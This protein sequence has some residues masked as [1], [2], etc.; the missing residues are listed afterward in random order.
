MRVALPSPI[1]PGDAVDLHVRFVTTLPPIFARTGYSEDFHVVA[2]WFPKIARRE[3]GGRWATFPYHGNGEFYADFAD[4]TLSVHAPSGWIVGANGK[5]RDE[6]REGLHRFEATQVHD[7]AFVAWPSFQESRFDAD[8]VRV[9]VLFPPGYENATARHIAMVRTGLA[10]MGARFGPYPWETLTVIV[11]PRGAEGASGMEY[12]GMF[13]TAGDA[14]TLEGLRY[15]FPEFVTAHELAHQWF[16]GA[17]ATDEV[18]WPMLDEGI[19]EWVSLDL[20]RVHTGKTRGSA[21]DLLGLSVDGFDIARSLAMSPQA[22]APGK[23]AYAFDPDSYGRS[24]YER[25]ATVLETVRRVW[26]RAKF[27]A[28]LS[29]YAR[30]HRFAHPTPD[31]LFRAFDQAYFEGFSD[32]V[33]RPALLDG[34]VASIRITRF[35]SEKDGASWRV[36]LRAERTGNIPVPTWVAL[37]DPKGQTIA[38]VAWAAREAE[39]RVT[40]SGT[41]EVASAEID[42]DHAI[43]LDDP[44]DN[45][46]AIESRPPDALFSR[47]LFLAQSLLGVFAP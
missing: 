3:P 42:P 44:L 16:Y 4:V 17:I 18:T 30:D 38:R 47:L 35:S 46:A 14:W 41:D 11:P 10:S 6:E 15:P 28:A 8:G 24:V 39:L 19:T 25:T 9:R 7:V 1:A 45:S 27:D 23:P 13:V 22:R 36:D 12:P 32:A 2:Q 34:E 26:G 31:S 33:L 37:R 40:W 5:R 20:L 43:L 21:I 29:A